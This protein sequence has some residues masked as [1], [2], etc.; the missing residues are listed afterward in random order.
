[1]AAMEPTTFLLTQ[2]RQFHSHHGPYAKKVKYLNFL[3]SVCLWLDANE[4]FGVVHYYKK[5]FNQP[6]HKMTVALEK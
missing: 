5:L 2:L 6:K 1:M 3:T 4:T